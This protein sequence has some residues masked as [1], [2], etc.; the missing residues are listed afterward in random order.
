MCKRFENAFTVR[1]KCSFLL[2]P[3]PFPLPPPIPVNPD[4]D[5]L[6][7]FFLKSLDLLSITNMALSPDPPFIS[8]PKSLT[9]ITSNLNKLSEVRAILSDVVAVDLQS[10]SLDIMEIQGSIEEIA[11]DKCQRAADRVSGV[12]DDDDDVVCILL[13]PLF[14]TP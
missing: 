6:P 10:R 12:D 7:L 1:R 5:T 14:L 2:K 13:N 8:R 9:F 4:Q 3:T 11:R